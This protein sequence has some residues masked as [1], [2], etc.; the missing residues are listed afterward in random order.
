MAVVP[1]G[2]E[3]SAGATRL[4]TRIARQFSSGEA[5]QLTA[6]ADRLLSRSGATYAE[7]L[8][9]DDLMAVVTGASAFFVAAGPLPRVRVFNP[10]RAT[11]GWESPYTVIEVAIRDEP[12]VVVTVR[13]FL[14]RRGCVVRHLLHPVLVPVRERD[15]GV[16]ALRVRGNEGAAECF[17]HV[18]VDAIADPGALAGTEAALQALLELVDLVGRDRHAMWAALEATAQ[19]LEWLVGRPALRERAAE[20]SEAAAF[21]RWLAAGNFL[22]IGVREHRDIPDGG[23]GPV[24]V[25]EASLGMALR[26]AGTTSTSMSMPGTAVAGGAALGVRDATIDS[27]FPPF[28]RATEIMV[29]RLAPDGA[30]LGV[31]S[32]LGVLSHRGAAAEPAEVPVLRGML[33]EILA[34]EAVLPGSHDEAEV[35]SLFNGFPKGLLFESSATEVLD[36][37]RSIRTASPERASV[38]IRPLATWLATGLA[39]GD[40]EDRDPAVA[41]R[42]GRRLAVLVS[43]PQHVVAS[44]VA[45]E[46]AARVA[47]LAGARAGARLVGWWCAGREGER[48]RI[49]VLLAGARNAA[50]LAEPSCAVELGA[51]VQP[52]DERLVSA[53]AARHPLAAARGIATRFRDVLPAG[54]AARI[55]G[56]TAAAVIERLLAVEETGALQVE[57]VPAVER[58]GVLRLYQPD[59]PLVLTDGV[60]TLAHLGLRVHGDE[61]VAV[62]LPGGRRV[63]IHEL[64]VEEIG[65]TSIGGEA[66]GRLEMVLRAIVAREIDDDQLNRLVVAGDLGIHAVHLLRAV[67]AYAVEAGAVT[68]SGATLRDAL[69]THQ[70]AAV[71]L[72]EHLRSR[73]AP[74]AAIG[75]IAGAHAGD[76]DA[77]PEATRQ[78]L[79]ARC[80]EIP[81]PA[82]SR[83]LWQLG[84]V[85][86]A[87]TRTNGFDAARGR[88][89][90]IAIKVD[91]RRLP[92]SASAFPLVET[93]V[94]SARVEGVFV[95]VGRAAHGSIELSP[96]PEGMRAAA[97]DRA[98]AAAVRGA[99][100][101]CAPAAG[102]FAIK[103]PHS[104][105]AV[106]EGYLTLL[107][108]MLDLM[109]ERR[110]GRLVRRS[111]GRVHDGEDVFLAVAPGEG[112]A[113]LLEAATGI[114]AERGWWLSGAF[115]S[116]GPGG[117]DPEALH[118]TARGAWECVRAHLR[119]AGRMIDD[120]LVVV[121]TGDMTDRFFGPG[122]V[123]SSSVRLR[124]A[125][126]RRYFFLDP[127]PDPDASLAERQ[128]LARQHLGWESYDVSKLSRGGMILARTAKRVRLSPEARV[129]LGLDER[130]V[131]GEQLAVAILGAPA[132]VLWA[133]SGESAPRLG[134]DAQGMAGGAE[135]AVS[136]HELRATVVAQGDLHGLTPKASAEFARAGGRINSY[137]VDGAAD[138]DLGDHEVVLNVLLDQ[139]EHEGG[140]GSDE[141]ERLRHEAAEAVVSRVLARVRAAHRTLSLETE[142]CRRD[143]ARYA[144][145]IEWLRSGDGLVASLEELR[146][147]ADASAA[148]A[149][150]RPLLG[151]LLACSK[152]RLREQLLRAPALLDD[153]VCEPFLTRRF[154]AV[155][156]ERFTEA[157]RRHALRREIIAAEVANEITDV[158]GAAFVP[159][160]AEDHEADPGTVM[161]C[162][163]VA[164]AAADLPSLLDSLSSLGH[165]FPDHAFPD[166]VSLD[167]DHGSDAAG[168][169]DASAQRAVQDAVVDGLRR[170]TVWALRVARGRPSAA[171]LREVGAAAAEV[172]TYL[173][174]CFSAVEAA[175]YQ[176]RVT[177]LEVGGVDPRV[178]RHLGVLEWLDRGLDAVRAAGDLG[179]PWELVARVDF[180]LSGW[181]DL[182]ALSKRI[183]ALDGDDV[184]RHRAVLG[185]SEDLRRVRDRLVRRLC[186]SGVAA[187]AEPAATRLAG[188]DAERVE[189]LLGELEMDGRGDLAALHVVVRALARLG[190]DRLGEGEHERGG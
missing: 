5:E 127:D 184:W 88:I 105:Q 178:A 93:F 190:E 47:Q 54:Y 139:V 36:D 81:A 21:L 118:V 125:V 109:D 185:L 101:V 51:A 115:V 53:L 25:P 149:F 157:I 148:D 133:G 107:R 78:A 121:G 26:D 123:A 154:P 20:L 188:R 150:T 98:V 144:R 41:A 77:D 117:Y 94:H 23:D 151:L 61:T 106:R 97:I 73:L 55:D 128:R 18:A 13:G 95:R 104:E 14:E 6:F 3:L 112:T 44:G 166:R 68:A 69:S 113:A 90:Y 140:L 19:D 147:V 79:Q 2:G 111:T 110:D 159:T 158:M 84:S 64:M 163:L 72:F 27:P 186:A 42:A 75:A 46:A 67:A 137:A 29:R 31:R 119:E 136:G 161:G 70:G 189:R 175:G 174:R 156:A 48:A 52:W 45:S 126:S 99:A 87:I 177:E 100:R 37:I 141:R 182:D 28:G 74:A 155:I 181:I 22:P 83:M 165:M 60:R 170:L 143:P 153:P 146:F 30:T 34:A 114:A 131:T 8:S 89:P 130:E 120:P 85:A 56:T 11:H 16:T 116:G 71:A 80:E 108:G 172:R 33:S 168:V 17:L 40:I 59:G 96:T 103:E 82:V 92:G 65:G 164:A 122:M 167:H 32:F 152:R 135:L 1:I 138:L 183:A 10:V 160:L 35:T 63:F 43:V 4:R 39:T 57:F 173:P 176:R 124:A 134:R 132:D 62:V 171:I 179:L 162:W 12:L 38:A 187:D 49:H 76:A 15:G 169:R 86:D 145:V 7:Q 24:R 91:A 50:A 66:A 142:R 58:R 180:G 129:L 9:D 102:G